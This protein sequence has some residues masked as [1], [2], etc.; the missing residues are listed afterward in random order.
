[1]KAY[2]KLSKKVL[3]LSQ[4]TTTPGEKIQSQNKHALKPIGTIKY[5]FGKHRIELF[6]DGRKCTQDEF[7]T[8]TYK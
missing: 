2:G 1:M 6:I 5:Y 7:I 3:K 4:K 8:L